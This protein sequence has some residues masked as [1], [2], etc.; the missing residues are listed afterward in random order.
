MGVLAGVAS[1]VAAIGGTG[2]A[3]IG[4]AIIVGAGASLL[5]ADCWL[6]GSPIDP[7]LICDGKNG[8][9][10]GGGGNTTSSGAFINNPASKVL[11]TTASPT[12]ASI[13]LNGINAQGHNYAVVR[14]GNI[15]A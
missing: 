10:V 1:T 8:G 4:G 5:V 3:I 9:A 11:S 12:C 2:A 6:P 14:G 13:I 15:I 7:G